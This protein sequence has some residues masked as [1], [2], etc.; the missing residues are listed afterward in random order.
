VA[1]VGGGLLFHEGVGMTHPLRH[2]S[3]Y[4][5]NRGVVV[6]V[7]A[8]FVFDSAAFRFALFARF[9]VVPLRLLFGYV[10]VGVGF[11]FRLQP[12][13]VCSR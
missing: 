3:Q 1:V 11:G 12:G 4:M 10:G 5:V 7:V 9:G 2:F 6:V 13:P 8:R